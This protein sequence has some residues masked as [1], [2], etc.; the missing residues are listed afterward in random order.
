MK[1]AL[2]IILFTV[3]ASSAMAQSSFTTFEYTVGFG[4]GDLKDYVSPV[5][6]R[7]F[8]FNYTNMVKPNVG[9]GFEVGWS[10]FYEKKPFD[11]YTTGNFSYSGKQWRY[12]D[13]V[14]MM[15]TFTFFKSPDSEISPFAGL[16][17]GTLYSHHRT[18]FGQ[19]TFTTDAWQFALR[20]E[21]GLMYNTGGASIALTG[22]YFYGFKGGDLPSQSFY[23]VNLGFVINR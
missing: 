1:K 2:Y 9:V 17:I 6:W 19:W 20:P 8:T 10:L 12:S 7:G 13:E 23:T 18:D 3:I 16:G 22:K 5:S 4:A 11:T 21:V 14:P 15:A